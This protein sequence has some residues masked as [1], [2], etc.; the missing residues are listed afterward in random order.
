[1]SLSGEGTSTGLPDLFTGTM[2][3]SIPIEV[4]PGRKGMYPG[5]ALNYRSGN[6]NGVIGVGWELDL[7]SIQ[8]PITNDSVNYGQDN[9]LLTRAGST[10]TLVS[11]RVAMWN[12][13]KYP[14]MISTGNCGDINDAINQN[15]GYFSQV[16]Y[17]VALYSTDKYRSGPIKPRLEA[18]NTNNS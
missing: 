17:Q 15:W 7:G 8:R 18:K 10:S 4:P 2:S 1:V 6:G 14:W 3:Y 12:R 5:L 13:S 11:T 16:L 9:Y